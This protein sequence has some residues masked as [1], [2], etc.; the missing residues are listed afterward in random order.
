MFLR[1]KKELDHV[2]FDIVYLAYLAGEEPKETI[3]TEVLRYK[4]TSEK[5]HYPRKPHYQ[6]F[7]IYQYLPVN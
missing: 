3:N 6:A 2:E 1:R 4:M 5:I 7:N